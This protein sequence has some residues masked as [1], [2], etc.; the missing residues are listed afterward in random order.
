MDSFWK[1]ENS[2]FESHLE[3]FSVKFLGGRLCSWTSFSHFY[4]FALT[5][6]PNVEVKNFVDIIIFFQNLSIFFFGRLRAEMKLYMTKLTHALA[7]LA[8]YESCDCHM[9]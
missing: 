2:K 9:A 8:L 6:P 4:Q 5:P 7:K 3:Q 1:G